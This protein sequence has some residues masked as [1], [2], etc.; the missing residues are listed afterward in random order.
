MGIFLYSN[1][2]KSHWQCHTKSQTV[3]E[4]RKHSYDPY[5]QSRDLCLTG[6][7]LFTQLYDH[8][9]GFCCSSSSAVRCIQLKLWDH[10]WFSKGNP[11]RICQKQYQFPFEAVKKIRVR[12]PHAPTARRHKVTL[13]SRSLPLAKEEQNWVILLSSNFLISI[14]IIIILIYLEN[15]YLVLWLNWRPITSEKWNSRQSSRK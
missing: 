1:V 14:M 4:D 9:R 7:V 15:L 2:W 6:R 10:L 8:H 3:M 5:S 11:D 12:I 13:L